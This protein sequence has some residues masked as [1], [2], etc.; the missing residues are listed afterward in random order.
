MFRNVIKKALNFGDILVF[1]KKISYKW[2]RILLRTDI[3][4]IKNY[5]SNHKIRKL[6]IGA[7]GGS[8]AWLVKF[9]Y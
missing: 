8:H 4:I 7:G 2:L 6:N 3:K 9:R 5:F 1:I